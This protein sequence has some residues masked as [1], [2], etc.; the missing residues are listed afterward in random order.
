MTPPSD[1][2]D[3]YTA[4]NAATGTFV[5]VIGVV[6][7]LMAPKSTATGE[8]VMTFKILDPRLR[9]A[10]YGS[11]GIT[12]R[13]FKKDQL[14]LP[15]VRNLG[16]IVLIRTIK[17]SPWNQQPVLLGN[18]QTTTVVFPAASIPDPGFQLAFQGTQRLECLGVPQDKELVTLQEQSYVMA[19]KND[20]KETVE[21]LPSINVVGF[22]T[23]GL[24]PDALGEPAAKRPRLS[25]PSL[26]SKPPPGV[27]FEPL[28]GRT[29]QSDGFPIPVPRQVRHSSFGP[30]FKTVKELAHYDFADICAQVVKKYPLPFGGCDLYVSDYTSN[31]AMW[32]YTPPEE[33][34]DIGREGDEYGYAGGPP[35]RNFPG[36]YGWNVLKINVKDPH[37]HFVNHKLADGDFVLLRN[38][39]MKVRS[40]GAKLEG[41]MWPDSK[42][43]EKVQAIK[44]MN[45]G[46]AE[47]Q[48]VLQRKEKYWASRK[49]KVENHEN[50]KLSR[51]E[52]RS[53]KKKKA[54][55][56]KKAAE[57]GALDVLLKEQS[58]ADVNPHVRCSNDE[59]PITAVWDILDPD[60]VRHTNSPPGGGESYI[61]PFINAKYRACVR[62]VDYEPQ[63]LEDFAIPADAEADDDGEKSVNSIDGMDW[64][65][66][67]KYVWSFRLQLEDAS[68]AANAATHNRVWMTFDH[69]SAQYLFGNSMEDPS[70]LHADQALLAKLRE[71]MCILWGNLEERK[72]L[73]QQ[74]E[75]DWNEDAAKLSNRPFECCVMEYGILVE[76]SGADGRLDGDGSFGYERM[77]AGFGVTIA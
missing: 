41:D 27:P 12:V 31:D 5:N 35:K 45:H 33:D 9:D 62:V 24:Q 30:K 38:V 26:P 49:A 2:S 42:N 71:K 58:K 67:Q 39:K 56:E 40:E 32:Y 60:N 25:E 4:Y 73:L 50:A 36:P 72:G 6:V 7:D 28:P 34:K 59:V 16:D 14:H 47:I 29:R 63:H 76:A 18:Y 21:G 19:L 43:P 65:T 22:G 74:N 10:I 1:F 77:Y 37:A 48:E 23:H 44:L 54:K 69:E 61:V 66:S 64:H 51:S 68:T 11:Q 70:N 15:R 46:L 75:G 53:K 8:W 57:A 55:A 17:C 13:F 52:K 20:M 3:L